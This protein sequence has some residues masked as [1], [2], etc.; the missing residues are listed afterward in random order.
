MEADFRREY[1]I[2]LRE[3]LARMGWNEFKNLL[4]N[5]SPDCALH[6]RWRETPQTGRAAAVDFW[7]ALSTL[8]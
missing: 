5:L 6:R 4:A 7:Q 1:G 2:R 8:G 3:E